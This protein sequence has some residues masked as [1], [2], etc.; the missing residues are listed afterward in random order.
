MTYPFFAL[1][2][3]LLAWNIADWE[4]SQVGPVETPNPQCFK[5]TSTISR[6]KTR[7]SQALGQVTQPNSSQFN[8]TQF[9]SMQFNAIQCKFN[10]S[11]IQF[12]SMQ[13]RV[14]SSSQL[15]LIQ[16]KFNP[17]HFS[18]NSNSIHFNSTQVKFKF[19]SIQFYSSWIDSD[20]IKSRRRCKNTNNFGTLVKSSDLTGL[21]KCNCFELTWIGLS[22]VELNW[23]FC[24]E[25]S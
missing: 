22:W 9:N 23:I 11:S 6:A 1:E 17:I 14:S 4:S 2:M 25:L 24:V 21:D 16:L 10:P 3:I 13:C 12:N 5:P 8:S 18:L 20:W 7:I 15:D 19:N